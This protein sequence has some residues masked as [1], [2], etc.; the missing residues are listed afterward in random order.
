[1]MLLDAKALNHQS[2]NE[3]IRESGDQIRLENVLGQRFIAAGMSGVTL[4]IHGT[5]GNA[6]GAYLNGAVINVH[7]NAQDAVGDTMNAGRINV[8][9]NIG[10][11]PGYAMRG[12]RIFVKGNAGY[13]AG[14]HMKA[15]REH[16]PVLVIGGKAGSFLGEYQA[17]G[18]IIVLGLNDDEKDIVGNFPCTGMHGGKMY[19]RSKCEGIHF[20]HQVTARPAN[21]D[22][23]AQID[24][25]IGEFCE[26][27]GYDKKAV[28][29]S[30]F[31]VVTP[32]SKNP[33]QQMYVAN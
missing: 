31:T 32:S 29:D 6:L 1:M 21:A 23:M 10:D 12:G 15:Y 20:P 30:V 25:Y 18:I 14:I 19:L 11:A 5:P 7:G 28:T 13:R 9:G 4:N 8:F 22:D 24:E 33:Y 17:G 27:F 3:R 16:L 2:L 26:L